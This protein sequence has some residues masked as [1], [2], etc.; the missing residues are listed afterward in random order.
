[1]AP[2]VEE[3]IKDEEKTLTGRDH[4]LILYNDDFN[5]F[6]FVIESLVKVCKHE[7]VQAEQCAFIVHF[8]GKCSVK[9][10]DRVILRSMRTALTDRGLTAE[11]S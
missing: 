9:K 4:E 1:M 7:A 10:G 8:N 3:A 6:D 11:V 5:T 2:D